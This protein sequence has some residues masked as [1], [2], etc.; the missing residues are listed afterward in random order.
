MS[1]AGVH[2]VFE[3]DMKN[4][5]RSNEIY[6]GSLMWNSIQVVRKNRH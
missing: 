4:G 1:D 3:K 5:S 2:I 6:E